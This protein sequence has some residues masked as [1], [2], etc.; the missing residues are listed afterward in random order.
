MEGNA[1][2]EQAGVVFFG[3]IW[4][5]DANMSPVLHRPGPQARRFRTMAKSATTTQPNKP[6]ETK[7]PQGTAGGQTPKPSNR[8]NGEVTPTY[9]Q[10]WEDRHDTVFDLLDRDARGIFDDGQPAGA[11]HEEAADRGTSTEAN[12]EPED[13]GVEP[14]PAGRQPA[15]AKSGQPITTR[16]QALSILQRDFKV[17]SA[18]FKALEKMSDAELVEAASA[19]RK[20]HVDQD[21]QGNIGR[22]SNSRLERLEGM[23]QGLLARKGASVP[24][25]ERP[26]DVPAG[27]Q[28]ANRFDRLIEA[29]RNG[30]GDEFADSLKEVFGEIRDQVGTVSHTTKAIERS[31]EMQELRTV[32]KGLVGQFPQ[33][34][35]DEGI[36]AVYPLMRSLIQSRRY[37]GLEALPKLMRDAA[38][39]EFGDEVESTAREQ[40]RQEHIE[41]EDSV[42]EPDAGS[43]GARRKDVIDTQE[44]ADTLAID[45][46]AEGKSPEEVRR[47]L[48]S[49]SQVSVS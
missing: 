17:N 41:T 15:P 10:A 46:L 25:D 32:A 3:A 4:P 37:K 43:T 36:K 19:R 30:M 40:L 48:R 27:E 20:V 24:D 35:T 38:R 45:L 13:E 23:V 26:D 47:I 29:A 11:E 44:K 5:I 34:G 14:S 12:N 2:Y 7:A 16:K 42:I 31:R 6:A 49:R 1:G 9:D 28:P 39:V 18:A 33:L 21:R 22:E 8:L